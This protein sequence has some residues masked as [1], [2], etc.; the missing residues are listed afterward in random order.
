M[1]KSESLHICL[2]KKY[3]HHNRADMVMFVSLVLRLCGDQPDGTVTET[4][5]TNTM[6][7]VF[8]SDTSYVDRGFDAEFEAIDMKDRKNFI[9]LKLDGVFFVIQAVSSLTNPVFH[10]LSKQ[11]PVQKSA[12]H[13]V[14]A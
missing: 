14:G 7:V 10:S 12:L 8:F 4:S 2:K 11:V 13:K 3:K 5:N 6:T 1:G 9:V